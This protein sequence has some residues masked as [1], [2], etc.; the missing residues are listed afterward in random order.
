LA[1]KC[2]GHVKF[3]KHSIH[4]KRKFALF[5]QCAHGIVKL[6]HLRRRHNR[7]LRIDTHDETVKNRGLQHPRG[8]TFSQRNV[9]VLSPC[10]GTSPSLDA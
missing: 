2:P 1:R 3:P 7:K 10:S 9:S 8:Y 5:E 6:S 4:G